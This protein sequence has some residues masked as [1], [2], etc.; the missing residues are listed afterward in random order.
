MGLWMLEG[1]GGIVR[2]KNETGHSILFTRS[3][4]QGKSLR[5]DQVGDNPGVTQLFSAKSR[6]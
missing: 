2:P 6:P 5:G 1:G 3:V 4:I